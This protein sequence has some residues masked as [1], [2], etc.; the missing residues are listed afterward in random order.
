MLA[1]ALSL[2]LRRRPLAGP[3]VDADSR[4][5]DGPARE[6]GALADS[7][8]ARFGTDASNSDAG[9]PVAAAKAANTPDSLLDAV[10]GE[11]AEPPR[12]RSSAAMALMTRGRK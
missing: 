8:F 7:A 9:I 3:A 12:D 10:P 4:N 5:R 6:D 2:V 1:L 11:T